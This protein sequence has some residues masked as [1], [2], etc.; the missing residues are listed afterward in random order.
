M[1]PSVGR[2]SRARQ[3]PPDDDDELIIGAEVRY[4]VSL[5]SFVCITYLIL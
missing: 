3:L 5:F 1:V 4:E 2:G